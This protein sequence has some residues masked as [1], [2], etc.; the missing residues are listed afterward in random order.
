[1]PKRKYD[2]GMMVDNKGKHKYKNRQD[3]FASCS[4]RAKE[5][6]EVR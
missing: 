2:Y 3:Y 6:K 1:M 5:A 4:L